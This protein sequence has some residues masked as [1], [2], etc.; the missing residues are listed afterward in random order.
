MR[1]SGDGNLAG[2]DRQAAIESVIRFQLIA[3]ILATLLLLAGFGAFIWASDRITLQGERT[4]FTVACSDGV[5]QG[6]HCTGRLAASERYTFRASRS[7]QEVLY[8]TVG[9]SVPSG[10]YTDCHVQNRG[11]WTCNVTLGHPTI[12]YEMR[13]DRPTHGAQGLSTPFHAVP[14]WKWW[15]LRYGLGHFTDATL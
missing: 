9:S 4:V 10:K 6:E 7:R 3:K 14:K 12:T 8:W 1:D 13:N 2:V 5:W 15:A 11:N